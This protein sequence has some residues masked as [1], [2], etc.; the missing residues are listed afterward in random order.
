MPALEKLLNTC[1]RNKRLVEQHTATTRSTLF[2]QITQSA[3]FVPVKALPLA[4]LQNE[5]VQGFYFF[6]VLFDVPFLHF[7][8][9]CRLLAIRISDTINMMIMMITMITICKITNRLNRK[10]YVGQIKQPIER[11][12]MQN[13]KA[14]S[15]LSNAMRDCGLDNFKIEAIEECTTQEQANDRERF[16]WNFPNA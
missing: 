6:R 12:F 9:S 8:S 3:E 15:P 13:A 11:R 16:T 1:G 7:L 2:K 4:F 5:S 14:D 10:P